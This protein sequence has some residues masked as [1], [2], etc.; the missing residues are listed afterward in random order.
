MGYDFRVSCISSS[1]TVRSRTTLSCNYSHSSSFSSF[2]CYR[3]IFIPMTI[4][5]ESHYM[6]HI[7]Y[8]EPVHK[9]NRT[10]A[11][12]SAKWIVHCEE[13]H[14][15]CCED[16]GKRVTVV[17][18]CWRHDVTAARVQ[19]CCYCDSQWACCCV[20]H[21]LLPLLSTTPSTPMDS[22]FPPQPAVAGDRE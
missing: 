7:Q 1:T 5:S 19:W 13:M 16:G 11:G 10:I 9:S 8:T 4:F 15:R 14:L 12:H 2:Y 6:T 3:I 18:A 22:L 17:A 20:S 21:T